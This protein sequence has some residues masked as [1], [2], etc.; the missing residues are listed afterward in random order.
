[1]ASLKQSIEAHRQALAEEPQRAP[2]TLTVECDL[3]EG[4][5]AEVVVGRHPVKVDEPR[6]M[7]GTGTAPAPVAYAMVASGSCEADC[8]ALLVGGARD[9]VRVRACQCG[10]PCRYHLSVETG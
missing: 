7:G 3:A 6:A 1:M 10:G 4:Y 2:F 9:P 8:P 5:Q